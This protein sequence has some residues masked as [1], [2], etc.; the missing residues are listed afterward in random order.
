[1]LQHM[2]RATGRPGAGDRT[3]RAVVGPSVTGRQRRD[4]RAS[5]D[6]DGHEL[7]PADHESPVVKK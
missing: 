1:M 7:A 2:T 6:G 4:Q 3:A 5:R